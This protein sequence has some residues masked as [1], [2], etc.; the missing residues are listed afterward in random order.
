MKFLSQEDVK[1]FLESKVDDLKK[2][3]T[4]E[5]LL[6]ELEYIASNVSSAT[7]AKIWLYDSN[8]QQ[9][10][11]KVLGKTIELKNQESIILEVVKLK[12]P[13]L[14]NRVNEHK[15][16]HPEIDN[17]MQKPI[18][19]ILVYPILNTTNQLV[20]VIQ[21][22]ITEGNFYQ[23][24]KDDQEN[25][26]NFTSF[27]LNTYSRFKQL[28]DDKSFSEADIEQV[29][30]TR[31]KDIIESKKHLEKLIAQKDQYFAEIVHELRTPLN[32]ILGFTELIQTDNM[33]SEK[34]D[35]INSILSS[36]NSMLELIND[37]LDSAK[38]QS[39]AIVV[40]PELFSLI[41]ELESLALLF[42][43]RMDKKNICFNTYIDP[44][45]PKLVKTDKKKIRQILSNLIGNSIKFTPNDGAIDLDVLY[46][47][48]SHSID[49]S[50]KDTGIGIEKDK[51][52]AIFE[53][54]TQ[55]DRTIAGEFGGTGLGLNIS[56]QFTAILGTQL[57]L[58]SEKGKGAKFFFNLA[59]Q[60]IDEV[61]PNLKAYNFKQLNT[62]KVALFLS[63][64]Y[65]KIQEL[66]ERYFKRADFNN[67]KVYDSYQSIPKDID[68]IICSIDNVNALNIIE[69][70]LNMTKVVV[71]RK[72]M[73]DELETKSDAITLLTIPIRFKKLYTTLLDV[74][75][76]SAI[77]DEQ[78]VE[79][80]V[81]IVDDNAI[82]AKYLKVV[83]EKLGANVLLGRDGSDAIELYKNHDLDML[84]LDEYM[85]QMNGSEAL[86]Q[87]QEIASKE[88]GKP[89]PNVIGISGMSNPDE[90]EK[91]HQCGFREI[92]S[93]PFSPDT[94]AK[95][96][97]EK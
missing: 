75:D 86:L 70:E 78:K 54:F 92:M 84:F 22:I 53:A 45:L 13:L 4:E 79:K 69:L 55:E 62:K 65:K 44:Q 90:L 27:F 85:Q 36:G 35:Y 9:L 18:K 43:S 10:V 80:L 33:E 3:E 11:S 93:K 1:A 6:K 7:D 94:I 66:L 88:G 30:A 97:F 58:E 51:Q 67:Y 82:S 50:V 42:A 71:Y 29:V 34:I 2:I 81:A 63:D 76:S 73:L 8:E 26:K 96:Y 57:R 64:N 15:L 74:H 12:L 21:A 16:Y 61:D 28:S 32:A 41:D 91:M 39:G 60:K 59:C 23:F 83:L 47:E 56:K 52:E 77:E 87:M 25:I 5:E 31:L 68:F 17:T 20:A 37:I 89:L 72:E 40:E 46:D 19:D 38:A 14:V 24:I 49:F 95:F 48:D